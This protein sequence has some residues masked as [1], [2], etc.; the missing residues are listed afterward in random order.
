MDGVNRDEKQGNTGKLNVQENSG[1]SSNNPNDRVSVFTPKIHGINAE[2]QHVY[3]LQWF[4]WATESAKLLVNT[5]FL[6]NYSSCPYHELNHMAMRILNII[7]FKEKDCYKL[8]FISYWKLFWT[9][10]RSWNPHE[11]IREKS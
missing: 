4:V 9:V 10:D 1:Y 8:T 5:N 2:L 3:S 6:V 7:T 11:W